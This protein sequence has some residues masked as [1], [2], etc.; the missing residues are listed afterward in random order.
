MAYIVTLVQGKCFISGIKSQF[1]VFVVVVVSFFF[2]CICLSDI[3]CA[4][5]Q[6]VASQLSAIP[7][8][9]LAK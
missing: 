5:C 6:C 4:S 1:A 9:V 8:G 2:V 7:L 3:C